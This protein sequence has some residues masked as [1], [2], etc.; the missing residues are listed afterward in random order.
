MIWYQL[1][2]IWSEVVPRKSDAMLIYVP[3]CKC[4][5]PSII[6]VR[7]LTIQKRQCIRLFSNCLHYLYSSVICNKCM[8]V[9][10]FHVCCTCKGLDKLK[11]PMLKEIL[12][13]VFR[14]IWIHNRTVVWLGL[15]CLT[16]LS[17][18]VQLQ[19]PVAQWVN[20]LGSWI[21]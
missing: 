17:T 13:K 12:K 2:S 8:L 9:I 4:V 7:A 1:L 19:G 21:T 10:Y 11:V 20:Q 14:T 16:P 15:W 6:L 18:I 5:R 3:Y